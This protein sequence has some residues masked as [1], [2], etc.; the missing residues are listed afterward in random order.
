MAALT[1]TLSQADLRLPRLRA[2][3]GAIRRLPFPGVHPLEGRVTRARAGDRQRPPP[4]P[5]DTGSC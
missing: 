4:A 2:G 5:G 3:R 1:V